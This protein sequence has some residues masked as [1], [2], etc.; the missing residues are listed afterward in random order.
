MNFT[1]YKKFLM[2]GSQSRKDR[3]GKPLK[4]FAF[5]ATLRETDFNLSG[6]DVY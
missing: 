3:K 2:R 5:F 1:P 4:N 6:I